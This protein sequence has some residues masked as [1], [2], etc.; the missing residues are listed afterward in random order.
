MGTT[1]AEAADFL[2]KIQIGNI[3][4]FVCCKVLA[5]AV[6]LCHC[7]LKQHRQ[8]VIEWAWLLFQ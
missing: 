1:P 8:Y 3:L 6:P 5:T 7:S 4:G 2:V